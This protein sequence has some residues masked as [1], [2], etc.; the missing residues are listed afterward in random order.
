M[1]GDAQ[2]PQQAPAVAP[3]AISVSRLVHY[4]LTEDDADKLNYNHPESASGAVSAGDVYPLLVT[5]VWSSTSVNG[6]VFTD[7]GRLAVIS[8]VEGTEPGY[9]FWPPRV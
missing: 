5:R 4:R 8:R 2:V 9:W 6:Q 1:E 7:T 3:P